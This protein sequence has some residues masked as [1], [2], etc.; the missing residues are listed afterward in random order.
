M[1]RLGRPDRAADAATKIVRTGRIDWAMGGHC[2]ACIL[3]GRPEG[4]LE[5]YAVMEG[6]EPAFAL[7]H[8]IARV[9]WA[10]E[11]DEWDVAR[12][13]AEDTLAEIEGPGLKNAFTTGHYANLIS[14][15]SRLYHR[16]PDD[17]VRGRETVAAQVRRLRAQ[18][19]RH[20][21]IFRIS[22]T[23]YEQ[24]NALI[25]LHEGRTGAG[26]RHLARGLRLAE[27]MGM[28]PDTVGLLLEGARW[29]LPGN[30]AGVERAAAI[31]RAQAMDR[32]LL[33]VEVVGRR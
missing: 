3:S 17:D 1:L 5:R 25:A 23:R 20:S 9:L 13:R 8:L 28:L 10:E 15:Y 16:T 24:A 32:L 30:A 19:K 11:Q 6:W 12:A 14:F 4:A 7:G 22:G 31:C 21:R 2:G 27:R 26:R 33:E 18:L 29:G